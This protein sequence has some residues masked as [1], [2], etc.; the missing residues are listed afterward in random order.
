MRFLTAYAKQF[1]NA[2]CT[3]SCANFR[4]LIIYKH[5]VFVSYVQVNVLVIRVKLVVVGD[6]EATAIV[7]IAVSDNS[8]CN[9]APLIPHFWGL[10]L[11]SS[12]VWPL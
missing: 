5:F 9:M 6:I 2:T 1:P 4:S 11:S 12:L 8:G 3:H 7:H 10:S